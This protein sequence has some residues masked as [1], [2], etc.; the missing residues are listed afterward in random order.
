M[1]SEPTLEI[2][3]STM[4]SKD[5]SFLKA[6]FPHHELVDLQILIVNQT[7]LNEDLVSDVES[8]RVINSRES[9]LSKSRNLA[10]EN[11]IGD[12]LV[13][14]DD[15]IQY[16]PNFEKTILEAYEKYDQASLISFQYLDENH[17]L[18]KI[19]PRKE[20]YIKRTKQYL[21]SVEMTFK[22]SHIQ[23]DK[24]R[25]NVDFGLGAKFVCAE[26]QVLRHVFISRGL[27][28][29]F[30]RTPILIHK[31]KTSTSDMGRPDLVRAITAY[32]YLVYKKWA[33]L[34]LLKYIFFL[35]RYD[36]IPFVDMLKTYRYGY[37]G[38]LEIIRTNR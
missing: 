24:L 6:M 38:I 9:G 5:I 1:N 21:S 36:Y 32:K 15:D 35:Y 34:W 10:I 23:H 25:F 18:S 7:Q 33:Y 8:I 13:I 30:V 4:N 16:L 29:V 22:A 27:K 31:G 26:E 2:L 28:V 20:G 14:A 3:I 11:A 12:I 19:Y 17:K 37:E